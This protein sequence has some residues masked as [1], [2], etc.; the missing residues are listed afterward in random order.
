MKRKLSPLPSSLFPPS[1]FTLIEVLL[2]SAI[3]AG[4]LSAVIFGVYQLLESHEKLTLQNEVVSSRQFVMGKLR[5]ALHGATV[6]TP[7][8]GATSATLSVNKQ[9]YAYNPL[10]FS[11]IDGVLQLQSGATVTPLTSSAVLADAW[12]FEHYDFSGI[13]GVSVAGFLG[14]RSGTSTVDTLYLTE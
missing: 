9:G 1:G 2:Y 7:A 8:V 5:W 14:N 6:N 3:V 12:V 4:M 10:I 11:V 13:S